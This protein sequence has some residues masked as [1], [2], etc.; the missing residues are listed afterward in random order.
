MESLNADHCRVELGIRVQ[1]LSK[2]LGGHVTATR[3]R[4][5]RMPGA[6]LRLEASS[7]C[8]FLHPFVN[9]KQV[10]MG[11]PDADPD[12]FRAAFSRKDSDAN[13]G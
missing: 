13:N 5:V 8:G 9:L 2:R 11:F 1:K 3:N 12:D 6:K 7:E 10:R 4:N